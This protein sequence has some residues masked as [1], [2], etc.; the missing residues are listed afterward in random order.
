M[1]LHELEIFVHVAGAKPKV[2]VAGL[3]D[4]LREVLT[5]A[6]IIQ[7]GQ[8]NILVFVG[9]CEEALHEPD[10][11]EYG[12][13]EHAPVDIDLTLEALELHRHL[14]VHCHPCR[15]VKVEVHMDGKA[16]G[17]LFSPATTIGCV[18]KWA[19]KRFGLDA[20]AA[21]EFVLQFSKESKQPRSDQH[22]GDLIKAPECFAC[23][24][25]VKELTP[26]G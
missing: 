22:L 17:R 2:V 12:E 3:S 9:E 11:V 16:A 18:T 20:G 4:K 1:E 24:D 15:H 5:Q 7:E 23:F 26:Q 8:D 14:H 6:E 13:D 21:A 25:L 19:H 10:N